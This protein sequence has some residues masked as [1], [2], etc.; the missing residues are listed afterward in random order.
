MLLVQFFFTVGAL[1]CVSVHVASEP[2][3]IS[4]G[5]HRQ[6]AEEAFLKRDYNKA[7]SHYD[8][9]IRQEP[10]NH[11]NHYKKY[12]VHRRMKKMS[13]ARDDLVKCVE[14]KNDYIAGIKGLAETS[15]H[16]GYC[17]EAAD[18]YHNLLSLR[19]GSSSPP[20]E[21]EVGEISE[22]RRKSAECA[23]YL[24]RA[25]QL[26][27]RGELKGER[28]H[29]NAALDTLDYPRWELLERKAQL[30][31]LMGEYYEVVA[32]MGAVI[33]KDSSNVN[34]YAIRGHAYFKLG[35][36][37]VA[38]QHFKEGLKMDPEVSCLLPVACCELP[39]ACCLL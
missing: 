27:E 20:S 18:H 4:P 38:V 29:L 31:H 21:K 6:I 16:L 34:A 2:S 23:S 1:S 32:D 28:D 37:E 33:K 17:R 9:A 13:D 14:L 19:N 7:L 25:G 5:K 35:E 12:T 24:E 26:R 8:K 3:A 10:K 39:V 30:N 11:V 15:H 22:G 36:H